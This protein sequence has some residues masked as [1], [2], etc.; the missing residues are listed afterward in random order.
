MA[1]RLPVGR[2]IISFAGAK[3]GAT[4]RFFIV[5]YD[6]VDIYPGDRCDFH[7]YS[8]YLQNGLCRWRFV[9]RSCWNKWFK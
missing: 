2:G 3:A 8:K 9:D 1:N 5:G 7:S 6:L 4:T